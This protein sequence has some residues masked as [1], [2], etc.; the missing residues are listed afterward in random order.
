MFQ[1]AK[2][3]F[4]ISSVTT[5]FALWKAL[6]LVWHHSYNSPLRHLRGPKGT[7]LMVGNLGEITNNVCN[8]HPT[9][10]RQ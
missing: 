7:S 5:A 4:A 3:L 9:R 1:I 10:I 2:L 6:R 8:Y